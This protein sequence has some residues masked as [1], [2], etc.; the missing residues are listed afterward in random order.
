M[1]GDPIQ[2]ML[3]YRMVKSKLS[4]KKLVLVA[5][6]CTVKALGIQ[7]NSGRNLVTDPN[8]ALHNDFEGWS[9]SNN[10]EV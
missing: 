3:R 9:H 7:F 1:K 5:S 6:S 10:V 4:L 2:I 8:T